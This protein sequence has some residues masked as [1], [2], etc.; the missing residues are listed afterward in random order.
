MPDV[1]FPAAV[2]AGLQSFLTPAVLLLVPSYLAYLGAETLDEILDR[3]EQDTNRRALAAAAAFVVGFATVVILTGAGSPPAGL[4]LRRYVETL[5]VLGAIAVLLMGFH[6]CGAFN[7]PFAAKGT[8]AR[9]PKP[10]G[11]WGPYVMGLAFAFGWTPV[12]GPK[13]AGILSIAGS[14]DGAFSGALLLAVYAISLGIP[15]L[16]LAF[17]V[18]P[19]VAL[20]RR[21]HARFSKVERWLGLF[22]VLTGM[23]FLTGTIAR[24]SLW[25]LDAFPALQR[26]G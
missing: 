22:L 10:P 14:R 4:E 19:F 21:L 7:M 16:V 20:V 9:V 24:W 1:S 25:A 3:R 8:R 17:L 26:L 12:V 18:R 2:V 6:F 15:F 23:L 11:L 5:R 13:L